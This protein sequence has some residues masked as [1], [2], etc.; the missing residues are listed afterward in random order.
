MKLST[1]IAAL[2]LTAL[3]T[4]AFAAPTV[5]NFDNVPDGTVINNTYG[6]QGITFAVE[7]ASPF[8]NDIQATADGSAFSSNALDATGGVVDIFLNPAQFGGGLSTFQV[9]S[10]ADPEGF[11]SSN[12]AFRFYGANDALLF[13]SVGYD[14]TQT[15]TF[16]FNQLGSVSRIALP[17]DAYYDDFSFT[18]TPNAAPPVPEASTLVSLGLLLAAGGLLTARRRKGASAA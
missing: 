7:N 5:I 10:L 8:S 4:L 13:T 14:Q 6:A 16:T 2:S 12:V 17:A 3:P 15:Q 18:D 1:L 11:G 9:T